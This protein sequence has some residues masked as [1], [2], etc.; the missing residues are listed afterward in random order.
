MKL[1]FE[2]N[3]K[4]IIALIN[5]DEATAYYNQYGI[6]GFLNSS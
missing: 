2:R 3:I 1:C 5:F 6:I 4:L